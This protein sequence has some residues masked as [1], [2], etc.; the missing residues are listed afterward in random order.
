MGL[1]VC[2]ILEIFTSALDQLN[3][4]YVCDLFEQTRE[5]S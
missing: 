3:I 2:V 4:D 5:V 1:H